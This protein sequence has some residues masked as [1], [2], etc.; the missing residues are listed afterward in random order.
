MS[1]SFCPQAS[2]PA[3]EKS[4]VTNLQPHRE[5]VEN[6]SWTTMVSTCFPLSSLRLFF[7]ALHGVCGHSK[8]KAKMM[9]S[10]M[11]SQVTE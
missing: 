11:K 9:T 3:S 1:D 5:S 2:I 7:L 10:L 8:A 6:Q 4:S